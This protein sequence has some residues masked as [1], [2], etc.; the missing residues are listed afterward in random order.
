MYIIFK[1]ELMPMSI[2]DGSAL[3]SLNT[4]SFVNLTS[5]SKRLNDFYRIN[6]TEQFTF[7]ISFFAFPLFTFHI[8]HSSHLFEFSNDLFILIAIISLF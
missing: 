1:R 7:L 2:E 4:V 5:S 8:F 3:V 6:K